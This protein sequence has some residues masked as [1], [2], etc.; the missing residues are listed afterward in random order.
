[1]QPVF[2]G[3]LP[4]NNDYEPKDLM[5]FADIGKDA[6]ELAAKFFDYYGSVFAGRVKLP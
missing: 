5:N 1:M 3:E 4:L 2:Q 6:P